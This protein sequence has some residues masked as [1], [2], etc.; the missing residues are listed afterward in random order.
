M[1]VLLWNRVTQIIFIIKGITMTKSDIDIALLVFGLYIDRLEREG[2]NKDETIHYKQ[3][4]L[5]IN[6]YAIRLA[7]YSPQ[8]RHAILMKLRG[9]PDHHEFVPRWLPCHK[10][11]LQPDFP[12][13]I[14]PND[15]C[16]CAKLL[17]KKES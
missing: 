4:Y 11:P 8:K 15:E 5:R 2:A 7:N 14:T 6:Q 12:P 1:V 16:L 17:I 10:L 3:A 9:L 13:C